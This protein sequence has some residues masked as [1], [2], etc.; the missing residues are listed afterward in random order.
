MPDGHVT[1]TP[2]IV[3]PPELTT[4]KV[5]VRFL[6]LTPLRSITEFPAKVIVPVCVPT[7]NPVGSAEI[8]TVSEAVPLMGCVIPEGS[9]AGEAVSQLAPEVAVQVSTDPGA[10]RLITETVPVT[11]PPLAVPENGNDPAL[12]LSVAFGSQTIT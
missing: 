7:L 12:K 9:A 5:T 8:T 3:D 11:R 2:V 6:G 4:S 10:P 1:L